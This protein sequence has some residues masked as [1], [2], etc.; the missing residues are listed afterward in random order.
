MIYRSNINIDNK[1]FDACADVNI[2]IVTINFYS[3]KILL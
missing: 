1:C 3:N 2:L